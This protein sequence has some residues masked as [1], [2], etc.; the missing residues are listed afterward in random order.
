[1]LIDYIINKLKFNAYLSDLHLQHGLGNK[2]IQG[3]DFEI[4]DWT[5][6][7][8]RFCPETKV[9]REFSIF[10]Y[11]YIWGCLTMLMLSHA[12]SAQDILAISPI[13]PSPA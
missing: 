2:K 4:F 7:R 12:S 3:L 11:R 9:Q 6:C 13:N 8:S 5:S 1:M 10:L